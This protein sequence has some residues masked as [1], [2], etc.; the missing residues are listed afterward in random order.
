MQAI[1]E[2]LGSILYNLLIFDSILKHSNF[3]NQLKIYK[4]SLQSSPK[5]ENSKFNEDL[6]RC[7]SNTINEF[8]LLLDG[9]L[10]DVAFD[11]IRALRANM[12]QK[13]LQK[14]SN[15]FMGHIKNLFQIVTRFEDKNLSEIYDT[16]IILELNIYCVLYH[17][18]CCTLDQKLFRTLVEINNKYCGITLIGGIIWNHVDFFKKRVPTLLKYAKVNQ[19]FNKILHA[20]LKEKLQSLGKETMNYAVHVRF[21]NLCLCTLLILSTL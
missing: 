10:V 8:K 4:K 3:K 14:L 21:L 2:D 7:L 5:D 17:T 20:F 13:V 15:Y 9:S 6:L 16:S 12:K 11:N 1:L 19:D 18:F